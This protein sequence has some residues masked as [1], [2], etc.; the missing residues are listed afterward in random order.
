MLSELIFQGLFRLIFGVA[1]A[2][3]TMIVDLGSAAVLAMRGRAKMHTW[4]YYRA[5]LVSLMLPVLP[6]I[7]SIIFLLTNPD[8]ASGVMA[9]II[10]IVFIVL[11]PVVVVS[12][13]YLF[14]HHLDVITPVAEPTPLMRSRL[15][16]AE[17][18]ISKG[19]YDHA[20]RILKQINH[21][22]ARALE[23]SLSHM[24]LSQQING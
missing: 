19:H 6:I 4:P 20:R 3:F 1:A 22:Q 23:E 12:I 11:Y 7:G 2:V 21:P 13:H 14:F 15:E 24:K 10:L 5:E 16:M 17:R 18:E 8:E 9:I